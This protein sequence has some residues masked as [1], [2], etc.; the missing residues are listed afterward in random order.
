M[1]E[2]LSV[3][4]NCKKNNAIDA[5]FC[6]HCGE[7]ISST[8][9]TLDSEISAS[10]D[11]MDNGSQKTKNDRTNKQTTLINNIID[12]ILFIGIIV[13]SLMESATILGA[14]R[15]VVY[16]LLILYCQNLFNQKRYIALALAIVFGFL[17]DTVFKAA[18]R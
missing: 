16:G 3:C 2:K 5:K 4:P 14:V 9:E 8:K 15:G 11:V 1:S 12:I 17:L 13:F 7:Q 6:S 18:M 10:K